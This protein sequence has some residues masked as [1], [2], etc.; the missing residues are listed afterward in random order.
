[1]NVKL[2]IV[3]EDPL[4]LYLHLDSRLIRVCVGGRD[5]V[6]KTLICK[7]A[8]SLKLGHISENAVQ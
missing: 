5:T 1:M 8:N 4:T 6:L 7:R 3:R 2:C